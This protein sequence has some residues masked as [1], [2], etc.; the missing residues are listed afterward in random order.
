MVMM[1]QYHA[2]PSHNIDNFGSMT[3]YH[4]I[5]LMDGFYLAIYNSMFI[6]NSIG[7][8]VKLIREYRGGA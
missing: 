3:Y 7:I 8:F 4:F 6:C 1:I 2:S 5:P